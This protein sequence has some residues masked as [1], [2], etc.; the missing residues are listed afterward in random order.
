MDP[1]NPKNLDDPLA[2]MERELADLGVDYGRLGNADQRRI[3][4]HIVSV[5]PA[6]WFDW[7]GTLTSLVP[8]LEPEDELP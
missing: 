6:P 1:E 3:R 7:L 8:A 4:K 2:W 5:F